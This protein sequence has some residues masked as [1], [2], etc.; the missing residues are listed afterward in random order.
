MQSSPEAIERE[1]KAHLTFSSSC[2][3]L[4]FYTSALARITHVS[5]IRFVFFPPSR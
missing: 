1:G 5:K 3:C 2:L 4:S